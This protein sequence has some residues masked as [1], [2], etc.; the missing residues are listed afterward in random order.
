ML[1]DMAAF[2]MSESADTLS[3]GSLGEVVVEGIR[4]RVRGD[5]GVM[6]VD[7]PAIVSDKPVTN[8]LE[9][10]GYLPG[11][12]NTSGVLG[13]AGASSVTIV[14]NG[15]PTDIPLQNLYQLLYNTPVDR[16]K[17]VEIM[18]SAPPKYHA[19][20]A[21][22]NVVL[23]KPSPL[24]GLQGQVR[25][26]YNQG[27]YASYGAGMAATY[28]VR[29]W[30]FDVNYGLSRSKTWSQEDAVSNHAVGGQRTSITDSMRRIG[31]NWSNTV[32]ASA[33]W[34]K[35]RLSYNGQIVSDSENRNL[36]SGTLGHFCNMN[37]YLSPIGFHNIAVRYTATFGL[38]VGGDYTRYSESRKQRLLHGGEGVLDAVSRQRINRLY[39]YADQEHNIGA[40]HLTYGAEYQRSEDRSGQHYDTAQMQVSGFS[41][42]L[43]EDVAGMYAGTRRTFD[44][45][46]SF[47]ASVKGEYLHSRYQRRW[48]VLPQIGA[49]YYRTQTSIFQ[50]NL[51]TRR[52]Y[53][54]YWELHG[55]T[56]Y[57]NDYSK[58][59]GNPALESAVDWAAQCNYVFRQKYVATLYFQYCDRSMVQLPYQSPHSLE[60][61]YQTVNMDYKRIVGVNL[62]APFTISDIWD[63]TATANIFSQREKATHFH[64]ISF[65]NSKLIFYGSLDSSLRLGRKSPL[66]LSIAFSYI[67]PSLQGIASLSEIWKADAGIKWQFGRQ[68]CCEFD[69]K[70]DDVFNRWSPLMTI[71]HAG[72]DYRMKVRDM[73]RNLKVTFVWRFNGFKPKD[74]VVDTSRFGTGK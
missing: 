50:I 40:W 48:N 31:Q 45:G 26:G 27:H 22:I 24:D 57:I 55:G 2:G 51:S 59:V 32:F 46:L 9:A 14:L 47:N 67:S 52:I 53:P 29:D 37:S 44:W 56:G 38:T 72:Q 74:T 16:L 13:L 3:S 60:L 30:T 8:I 25:G 62:Y 17:N 18:Y 39:I 63:I 35:L 42:L 58:V 1:S 23:K 28:A 71:R 21:V 36:S 11:V 70:A 61:I 41:D 66:S 54:S 43:T 68:R 19:E 69:V 7:L 5:D 15:E 34:R 12:T 33:S 65:D 10:L 6:V 73:S 4:P 49:T 64:D 20:G